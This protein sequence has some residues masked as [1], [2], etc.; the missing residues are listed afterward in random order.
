M[1]KRIV[2][3]LIAATALG[4]TFAACAKEES[5]LPEFYT[6][7]FFM[8]D[9]TEQ[10]VRVE[11]GGNLYSDQIPVLEIEGDTGAKWSRTQFDNIESDIIVTV[12]NTNAKPIDYT[13]TYT[14]GD[15][16]T[17][18]EGVSATAT[19]TYDAPYTLVEPDVP[20]GTYFWYWYSGEGENA[21]PFGISGTWK[22]A[23]N[24]TLAARYEE[25]PEGKVAVRFEPGNGEAP[26]YE[27]VNEGG[28]YEGEL[29]AVPEIPGY[30]VAWNKTKE[31]LVN[32]T[33]DVTVSLVKT[34]KKYT[35]TLDVSS[36]Q[37][38]TIETTSVEVTYNE[39]PVI[40][41]PVVPATSDYDFAGWKIEG[42]DV[43]ILANMPYTYTENKTLVAQW[44]E[45]EVW[46]D[47]Y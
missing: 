34:P 20:E 7:T 3:L 9:G 27:W 44:K 21:K 36:L 6:V 38:A 42:T 1:K 4:A 8:P 31:E 10:K 46:T 11:K 26:V 28:A 39:I 18:P 17:L 15:G 25:R 12:D 37:G 33:E 30:D 24:V 45:R 43:W 22:T 13:V 2:S 35:L 14:V 23:E 47:F 5:P 40:P 19:V 29:P 16:V 32:L 41:T